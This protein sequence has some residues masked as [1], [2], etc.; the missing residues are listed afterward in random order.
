MG[1]RAVR[2]TPVPK[3]TT[4]FDGAGRDA[5]RSGFRSAGDINN[6]VWRSAACFDGELPFRCSRRADQPTPRSRAAAILAAVGANSMFGGLA[7]ILAVLAVF[8]GNF[9]KAAKFEL[10]GLGSRFGGVAK[11]LRREARGLRRYGL[12]WTTGIQTGVKRGSRGSFLRFLC[13]LLFKIFA[14]LHGEHGSAGGT[15][16]QNHGNL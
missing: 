5:G 1:R 8:L 10:G 16:F 12:T 4:M 14:T 6:E 3:D 11:G 15:G 13:F 9:I 2:P 7:R